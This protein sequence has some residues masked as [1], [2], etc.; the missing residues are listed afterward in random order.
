MIGKI[1]RKTK[2]RE[3]AFS[4]VELMVG[5]AI[6][7]LLGVLAYRGVASG[8]QTQFQESSLQ[9]L[10]KQALNAIEQ[11]F[12][13]LRSV[14]YTHRKYGVRP[15]AYQPGVGL[16]GS[17]WITVMIPDDADHELRQFQT[18]IDPN[19]LSNSAS[20]LDVRQ[21]SDL[22]GVPGPA[23]GERVLAY[24]P[25]QFA[26][27][28]VATK[29]ENAG[30][31][32]Q[33]SF[34]PISI[35]EQS[36]S[37]Y[38]GIEQQYPE[39]LD[40]FP[41]RQTFFQKVHVVSYKIVT[42]DGKNYLARV[43]D[44]SEAV[45]APME[46]ISFAFVGPSNDP[47]ETGLLVC[48]SNEDT[49]VI[50]C[51]PEETSVNWANVASV[52]VNFEVDL[53]DSKQRNFGVRVAFSGDPVSESEES[54]SVAVSPTGE[55]SNMTTG[56]PEL[57]V[58]SD[59]TAQLL[60]PA[61]N[62]DVSA[63]TSSG[64][65]VLVD[66]DS[67]TSQGTL[68]LSLSGGEPFLPRGVVLDPGANSSGV[69][70][71][72]YAEVGGAPKPAIIH[73]ARD[74]NG[75]ISA[76][77]TMTS[78]VFTEETG[79]RDTV[80]LAVLED[81]TDG[82]HIYMAGYTGE[83]NEVHIYRTSFSN[84]SFATPTSV[85]SET[86]VGDVR[87]T[88]LG[89]GPW[90]FKQDYSN[91]DGPDRF[92]AVCFSNSADGL[93]DGTVK[94]IKYASGSS[95]GPTGALE[96]TATT[97][98]THNHE[99]SSVQFDKIG[100]AYIGG[101]LM[102]LT[103]SSSDVFDQIYNGATPS[104][105]QTDPMSYNTEDAVMYYADSYKI[106]GSAFS[107]SVS[108]SERTVERN[109]GY[110]IASSS[111]VTRAAFSDDLIASGARAFTGRLIHGGAT[112][113]L[114]AEVKTKGGNLNDSDVFTVHHPGTFQNPP[115]WV[116][117]GRLSALNKQATPTPTCRDRSDAFSCFAELLDV[118]SPGAPTPTPTPVPTST[119]TPTPT[120]TATPTPNVSGP[121]GPGDP[122]GVVD[123]DGG[124]GGGSGGCKIDCN[125]DGQD[126]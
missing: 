38:P 25:G 91:N 80:S 21:N 12:A 81:G 122:G 115:G 28:Q 54:T 37:S 95:A 112:P 103:I 59:G 51:P 77:S 74:G 9:R 2:N 47:L 53:T 102:A 85:Y 13:D 6:T 23:V 70:V 111:G 32:E 67:G 20:I 107:P 45:L 3:F 73:I 109:R 123:G 113:A 119:P 31:L 90:T 57:D 93:E 118:D 34:S 114:L 15:I 86:G 26:V 66:A 98:A 65:I 75:K 27:L 60:Q 46:T 97:I 89:P 121:G 87:I 49:G 106:F 56:R 16:N 62:F 108:L 7:G 1:K 69:Y 55:I 83:D 35:S 104:S 22:T 4:M 120:P 11:L 50:T 101:T 33:I 41:V 68:T 39:T 64:H 88:A 48:V 105:I 79:L 100:H 84:G 124:G 96:G 5:L 52:N 10:D 24:S 36:T 40:T 92:L 17:D 78:N 43:F 117:P 42:R 126:P 29:V 125:A 71:H 58:Y 116:F 82:P 19:D 14:D 44:G 110:A 94:L 63:G 61:V 18:D 76:S 8:I 30:T 99:C 72:G